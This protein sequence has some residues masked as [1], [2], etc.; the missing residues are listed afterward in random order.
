MLALTAIDDVT[1]VS[2][3]SETL[4]DLLV[5]DGTNYVNK[6]KHEI[7]PAMHLQ[8]QTAQTYF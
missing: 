8:K 3:S 5:Y 6:G 4:N 2:S 1:D 7:A